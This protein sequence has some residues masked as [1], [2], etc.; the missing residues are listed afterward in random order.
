MKFLICF[1]LWL[2]SAFAVA[3]PQHLPSMIDNGQNG[4]KMEKFRDP[5]PQ[6]KFIVSHI[7]C[8]EFDQNKGT[9]TVYKWYS[10]TF[11]N[12]QG[13]C[14]QEGDVL[15]CYGNYEPYKNYAWIGNDAFT[16]SIYSFYEA[17][18]HWWE[19]RDSADGY[20]RIIDFANVKLTRLGRCPVD[21]GQSRSMAANP[22]EHY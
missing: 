6:H 22:G 19:W 7:L 9:Q 17:A 13:R 3:L 10:T 16:F 21:P 20:G 14:V 12:W 11:P 18:G 2:F 1:Y 15:Q 8:F 5:D 4:W